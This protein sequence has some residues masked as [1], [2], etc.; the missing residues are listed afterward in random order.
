MIAESLCVVVCEAVFI[1]VCLAIGWH[2]ERRQRR[3][4]RAM[5]GLKPEGR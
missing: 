1:G 3:K 2:F 4:E 5:L